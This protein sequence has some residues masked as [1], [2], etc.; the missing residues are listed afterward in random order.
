MR[1]AK[2]MLLLVAAV[3]VARSSMM[4]W[5]AQLETQRKLVDLAT[6]IAQRPV[7]VAQ[8][9]PVTPPPLLLPPLP[10]VPI[11]AIM[12]CSG[13][14]STTGTYSPSGT[15]AVHTASNVELN[16]PPVMPQ[17]PLAKDKYE[18]APVVPPQ[19]LPAEISYSSPPAYAIEAPD[20]LIIE[21][22]IYDPKSRT[23]ERFPIQTSGKEFLVRPDGTVGLG[24]WGS[25]SVTG[26]TLEQ[27]A[28]SIRR[29]LARQS[30][31]Y[32]RGIAPEDL[33]VKVD[34]Q[35]SNSKA[36]YVIVDIGEKG[37]QVFRFPCTGSDTVADAIAQIPHLSE[38]A[39]MAM[40]HVDR[41]GAK[42]NPDL[43]L[44]VYWA[45]ITRGI[46]STNY[47]LLPGDRLYLK[48][49]K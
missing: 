10:T 28:D 37:E 8:S 1:Y 36:Y 47:Q 4:N 27:A 31:L 9:S 45:A 29:H 34:V 5:Q 32:S 21:A 23:T 38:V 46:T 41:K 49:S 33:R 20:V 24:V 44:P 15:S 13:N 7:E 42:G 26:L 11:P 19:R 48:G 18:I 6:A 2:F 17:Q 43:I 40:I 35:A 14:S 30:G 25:V 12:P 22:D 16:P 3:I 39:P